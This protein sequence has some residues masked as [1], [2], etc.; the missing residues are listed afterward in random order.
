MLCGRA[1]EST[2][3]RAGCVCGAHSACQTHTVDFSVLSSCLE[4]EKWK[5]PDP[6]ILPKRRPRW[7]ATIT[8]APSIP[9]CSS[10]YFNESTINKEMEQLPK[11][12]LVLQQWKPYFVNAGIEFPYKATGPCWGPSPV[13]PNTTTTSHLL[14]LVLP[15]RSCELI[16][17]T[18]IRPPQHTHTHTKLPPFGWKCKLYNSAYWFAV[19]HWPV[20]VHTWLI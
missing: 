17:A 18:V 15:T 12:E 16:C 14:L 9:L 20:T 5:R 6:G 2:D 3:S 4:K 13:S 7:R 11:G 10:F 19:A 8:P 1:W